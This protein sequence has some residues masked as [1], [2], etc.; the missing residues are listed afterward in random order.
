MLQSG[1]PVGAGPAVALRWMATGTS[2]VTGEIV[3]IAG[4]CGA[5][6]GTDD[7]YRVRAYETTLRAARFNNAG[8]QRTV[9]VIANPGATAASLT[10]RFWAADGTLLGTHTPA[11]PL[12]PHGVLVL[13]TSAIVP[14]ASGSVTVA[15]DAPYD[16]LVGK[17]VALE[18]ST[19]FS[20]DTPFEPRR[21]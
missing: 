2:P 6:C 13:D 21:R 8:D 18:P 5:A 15:H 16:G 10:V 11:A 14:G 20:F 4:D 3:R 12:A 9:V 17:T 7:V 19:G 1:T